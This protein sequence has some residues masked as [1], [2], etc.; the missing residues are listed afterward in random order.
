MSL[1]RLSLVLAAGW[2]LAAGCGRFAADSLASGTPPNGAVRVGIVPRAG[3]SAYWKAVE[4]GAK[5]AAVDLKVELLWKPP[6]QDGDRVFQVQAVESLLT[7]DIQAIGLAPLDAK[8]PLR[9]LQQA[10]RRLPVVLMESPMEGEPGRDY[11][12]LVGTDHRHAGRRAAIEV[13]RLLQGHGRVAILRGENPGPEALER[14]AGFREV[15]ERQPDL[16]LDTTVLNLE[17]RRSPEPALAEGLRGADGLYAAHE[18]AARAVLRVLRGADLRLRV[19]VGHDESGL[20]LPAVEE[21]GVR[22]LFL[23]DPERIGYEAVKAL[24][25]AARGRAVPPRVDIGVALINAE[26]RHSPEIKALLGE[27]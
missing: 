22:A 17:D 15:A 13:I 27:N 19:F 21:E 4:N 16:A 8:L 18:S 2:L 10:P 24:A 9:P 12:T 11:V 1:Y 14:E 5:R 23:Q 3:G 25:A 20:L 6:L 26:N 7:E